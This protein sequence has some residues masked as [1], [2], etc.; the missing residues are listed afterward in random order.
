MKTQVWI[1]I[2][3]FTTLASPQMSRAATGLDE[4]LEPTKEESSNVFSEMGVVQKKAMRKGGR[5]LLSSYM[6]LDFSDGPYTSYS[7][8]L[9]PGF[10][11]S[12]FFEIYASIAPQ[13]FVSPRQIVGIVNGIPVQG[14]GTYT[15][16]E[17]RPKYE[18]GIELLWAPLYGKDSFGVS[19]VIRSDTFLKVG[20]SQV[21]YDSTT[22]MS[23][24]LGVGKT[25]FLGKWLGIRFCLDYDYVQTVIDS[26]KKYNG[27]L[28][29]ELGTMF[30]F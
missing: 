2:F 24:R 25:F 10:A 7:L 5:F 13:Y 6:A 26:K 21:T 23:F 19:R 29:T 22:G 15:I 20:A 17:A 14:G 27:L 1:I 12:D 30:Y 9:N 16:V 3:I 18:Y 4:T 8:H 11:I 28:L